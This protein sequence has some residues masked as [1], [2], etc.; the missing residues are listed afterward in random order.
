MTQF[1]ADAIGLALLIF[2]ATVAALC[3][4]PT[5]AVVAWLASAGVSV[6]LL[7]ARYGRPPLVDVSRET[8]GAS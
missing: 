6:I 4:S 7:G 2:A 5:A 1:T 8:E 3:Y